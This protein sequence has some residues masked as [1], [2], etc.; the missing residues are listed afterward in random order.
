MKKKILITGS[1]GFLGSN[2][3]KHI[4]NKFILLKYDKKINGDLPIDL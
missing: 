1:E 3:C 4:K 2:F